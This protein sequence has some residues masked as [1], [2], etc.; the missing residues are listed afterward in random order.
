MSTSYLSVT[1]QRNYPNQIQDAGF[2]SLCT[3]QPTNPIKVKVLLSL[4]YIQVSPLIIVETKLA[5]VQDIIIIIIIQV[6]VV[7]VQVILT[8]RVLAMASAKDGKS[9]VNSN[10]NL[11]LQLFSKA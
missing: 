3:S 8:V 10:K 4:H 7:L 1:S 9:A 2:P 6:K 11:K 5:L